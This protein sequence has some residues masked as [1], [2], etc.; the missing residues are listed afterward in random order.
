MK[1]IIKLLLFSALSFIT[2]IAFAQ[3]DSARTTKAKITQ[4]T[5]MVIPR[6]N[7]GQDVRT[8]L[9]QSSAIRI[10]IA[11]IKE[12][13]DKLGFRTFDFVA[14]LNAVKTDQAFMSLN[15]SDAKAKIIENS[16]T[17]LYVEADVIINQGSDGLNTATIPLQC[18]DASSGLDIGI[19]SD[20]CR[21]ENTT[22]D[23]GALVGAALGDV[24][25][26]NF[27]NSISAGFE[28][29]RTNGRPVKMQVRPSSSCGGNLSTQVSSSGDDVTDIIRNWL[30]E[31]TVSD[32]VDKGSNDLL[33]DLDLVTVPFLDSRG[34][35]YKPYD[36]GHDMI[37]FLRT[38]NIM[39]KSEIR[40]GTIYVTINKITPSK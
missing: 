23:I 9:D 37:A 28:S 25:L 21:R 19:N 27:L 17:D 22:T 1:K 18:F 2:T 26:Q 24:C 7:A 13:F 4:M 8:I 39:S 35:N 20:G 30:K 33:L 16:G 15:P 3:R 31:H 10:G 34:K 12:A 40:N 36:F 5:L 38:K 6:T 14:S 11:K 29:M 32:F